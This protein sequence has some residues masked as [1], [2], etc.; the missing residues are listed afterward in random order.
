MCCI[1]TGSLCCVC[2]VVWECVFGCVTPSLLFWKNGQLKQ[3]PSYKIMCEQPLSFPPHTI[4]V[5][6]YCTGEI[7]P[8]PTVE[9]IWSLPLNLTLPLSFSPPFVS[10]P[11]HTFPWGWRDC[12]SRRTEVELFAP[13][14]QVC[15]FFSLLLLKPTLQFLL[16]PPA[17]WKYPEQSQWL[18]SSCCLLGLL[19]HF[20]NSV[21]GTQSLGCTCWFLL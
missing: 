18:L 14:A 15:L 3:P 12:D 7:K 20:P 21:L 11:C 17:R 1:V 19:Q 2:V 13:A 5:Y 10:F 16:L 9:A 8:L 4:P 6:K